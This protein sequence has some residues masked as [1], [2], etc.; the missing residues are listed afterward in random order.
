MAAIVRLARA[1]HLS[2]IAEGVE[3]NEQ[4]LRLARAGCS[5]VQGYLFGRPSPPDIIDKLLNGET[6]HSS[7]SIAV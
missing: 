2:V 3:T 5:E 1:L 4:R 7:Q 6:D